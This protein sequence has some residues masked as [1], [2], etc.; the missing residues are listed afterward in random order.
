MSLPERHWP[1][2]LRPGD[3]VALVATSSPLQTQLL[4]RIP[5]AVSVLESWGLRVELARN[6]ESRHLYLAGTDK[7]RVQEFERLY[8]AP[9]IRALFAVRGGY[10]AMRLLSGLNPQAFTG[11]RKLMVG[12]S[13]LTSLLHYLGHHGQQVTLH[14]PCVVTEQLLDEP[15]NQ[16]ALRRWVM[17]DAPPPEPYS[18][19]PLRPGQATG[20]LTGGCLSLVVATLGTPYEIQTEGQILFLEDVGEAP[21]RIDRMLTHL[22]EAGKFEKIRGLVFGRWS[23]CGAP[24]ELA[25]ML[26]DW[27]GNT[28]FPVGQNL[29]CGHGPLNWP[30]PLGAKVTLDADGGR[31]SFARRLSA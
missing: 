4:A 24:E 8:R 17:Q 13:D 12:F 22:R 16:E 29:P 14:G 15:R 20:V 18:L 28:P 25:A 9:S 1:E 31:L 19:E 11:L 10:G 30:L 21:Y 23:S 6:L 3:S 5:E 27:L 26:E 2:R 7:Q